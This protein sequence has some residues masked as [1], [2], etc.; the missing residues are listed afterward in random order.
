MGSIHGKTLMSLL[1]PFI[2]N[3][4]FS[5]GKYEQAGKAQE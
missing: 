5:D 1:E 4:L 2:L 3:G